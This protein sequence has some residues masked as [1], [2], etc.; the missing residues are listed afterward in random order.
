LLFKVNH[1]SDAQDPALVAEFHDAMLDVYR[2]AK[3]EAGYNATRFLEMVTSEGGLTTAR[4]LLASPTVSDGFAALWAAGRQDLTVEAV[5]LQPE[6][7]ALFTPGELQQA[8]S[9]LGLPAPDSPSTQLT[10]GPEPAPSSVSADAGGD[11]EVEPGDSVEQ[12]EAESVLLRRLEARIGVRLEP[13]RFGADEGL[14]IEVDGYSASP[15]V[16]VEV[17]A[18]IGPPKS[19]QKHKVL[20]DALKLVWLDRRFWDGRSRKILLFADTAAAR[21][22]EGRSWMGAAIR[23]LG[24]ELLTE[25]LPAELRER[26]LVAQA[27]QYR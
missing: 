20:A 26:V 5:V 9:R 18:H 19:A 21:Q 25:E 1:V 23:D 4:R 6:F 16:L 2:R 17:W 11:S 15:V 24:I 27:R 3:Q 22:F 10:S 13:H 7:A 8:A 12:R 14:R